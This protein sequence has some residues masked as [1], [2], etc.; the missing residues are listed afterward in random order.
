MDVIVELHS[1]EPFVP[2]V[3]LEEEQSQWPTT[4]N[5]ITYELRSLDG[6]TTHE[7]SALAVTTGAMRGNIQPDN[8]M[9]EQEERSSDEAP[10]LS[11]LKKV[12]RTA[13]RVTK[14]LEVGN[15]ILQD[16]ERPNIIHDLEGNEMGEWE[17][18]SI[19]LDK[20]DGTKMTM[21]DKP[22]GYDLW[23]DLSSLKADITFGQLLEISPMARKTQGGHAYD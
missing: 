1:D 3:S 21:E 19:P 13:R 16:R 5:V 2:Q 15:E 14:A 23:A 17:G 8:E 6:G 9:E 22:N 7:A 20:F 10:Q 4:A 18:P 11:D 12:A